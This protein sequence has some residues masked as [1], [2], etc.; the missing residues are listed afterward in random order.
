MLGLTLQLNLKMTDMMKKIACLSLL[1]LLLVSCSNTNS[2]TN[3]TNAQNRSY[4]ED[5]LDVESS[6]STT[7][8]YEGASPD[9][10]DFINALVEEE[11]GMPMDSGNF[12][13]AWLYYMRHGKQKPGTTVF[14][15]KK[16]GYASITSEYSIEYDGGVNKCKSIYEMCFWNCDDGK[17]KLF[18]LNH[19]FMVNGRYREGQTTGIN[20]SLYEDARHIMWNVVAAELGVNVH[21]D[22]DEDAEYDSETGL[23]HVK[24]RETGKP[25][26]LND[27]EYLRWLEEK[28]VVTY[29]LPKQGKDII[30]EI[31]HPTRTETFRLVWDGMQF[32]RQ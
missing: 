14:V 31:H 29:W 25:L 18:A 16:N 23:T 15:D 7:V 26:K 5:M 32:T 17:H 4:P 8:K 27:D 6:Y 30:A 11:E 1:I 12:I 2:N 20:F 28:P 22:T 9:I 3:N 19:N 13:D 10:T 24:D 21:P